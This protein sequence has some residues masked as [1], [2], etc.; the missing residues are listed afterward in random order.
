MALKL[1]LRQLIIALIQSVICTN[2]LIRI[3]NN[4][5]VIRT[6]QFRNFFFNRSSVVDLLFVASCPQHSFGLMKDYFI[7]FEDGVLGVPNNEGA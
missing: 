1:S 6:L 5:T 3:V 7:C 4:V 2:I